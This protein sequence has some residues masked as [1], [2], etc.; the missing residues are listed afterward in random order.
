[1]K[2]RTATNKYLKEYRQCRVSS[3]SNRIYNGGNL[4][5]TCRYRF[6]KYGCYDLPSHKGIPS[7]LE[8][9]IAPD[10]AAGK[11]KIHGYL[12]SDEMYRSHTYKNEARYKT[13]GCRRCVLDR[14]IKKNYGL[15]G[16]IDEYE[17]LVKEQN[18]ICQI[19]KKTKIALSPDRNTKR[20]LSIDHCHETGKFRGILCT[21]CNSGLGYFK[22]SIE[23]LQAAIDYLKKHKEDASTFSPPSAISTA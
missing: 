18:S 20:Q 16:G 17:H 22:D 4:C 21:F 23:S 11:C 3:C 1:M 6:Q 9:E 7:T 13:K 10:W 19:C 2:D 12:T 5:S 15:Q 14:N 8:I